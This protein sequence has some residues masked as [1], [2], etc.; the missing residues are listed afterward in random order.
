[1]DKHLGV[2]FVLC[3]LGAERMQNVEPLD[4]AYR[5]AHMVCPLCT[6]CVCV[7]CVCRC[8][9]VCISRNIETCIPKV[10][11]QIVFGLSAILPQEAS[12][13]CRL[14]L[15]YGESRDIIPSMR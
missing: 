10:P 4:S 3:S 11:V 2:L 1:M 12:H 9:Y 5:P 7:V 15:S 13:G 14:S 8:M 6:Y